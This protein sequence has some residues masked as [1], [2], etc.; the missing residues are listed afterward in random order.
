M[1]FDRLHQAARDAR[2][3]GQRIVLLSPDEFGPARTRSI[4]SLKANARSTELKRVGSVFQPGA[5]NSGAD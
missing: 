4:A 5:L 2:A 1:D 3:K